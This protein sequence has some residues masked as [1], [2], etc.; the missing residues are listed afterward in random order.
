M[1]SD[2]ALDADQAGSTAGELL[3]A[4]LATSTSLGRVPAAR[5]DIPLRIP[6]HQETA[7]R[8]VLRFVARTHQ[9]TAWW[10]ARVSAT[11]RRRRSSPRCSSWAACR[12]RRRTEG[13]V[14]DSDVEGPTRCPCSS[15]VEHDGLLRRSGGSGVPQVRAVDDR[16]FQ[17]LGAVDGEDLDGLGV[18][19]EPPAAVLGVGGLGVG[20]LDPAGQPGPQVR[21]AQLAGGSLGVKQLADVPEVGELPLAGCVG[22]DPRRASLRSQH[23]P[24][25]R[26]HAEPSQRCPP[27]D[28]SGRAVPPRRPRRLRRPPRRSYPRMGSGP[29]PQRGIARRAARGPPAAGANARRR[30][31]AKTLSVLPT[32]AGTPRLGARTA[33]S[34]LAVGADEHGD[35]ARRPA[36]GCGPAGRPGS[37]RRAPAIEQAHDVGS[38]VTG[39]PVEG[40]ILLRALGR[41]PDE[42]VGGVQHPDPERGCCRRAIKPG[43]PMGGSGGHRAV[44]DVGMTDDATGSSRAS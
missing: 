28:A 10:R 11:Y 33:R 2:A 43:L 23:G 8:R 21:G 14:A 3:R 40:G 35:V 38:Q 1:Y 27:S 41:R 24:G 5:R 36:R 9:I 17:P 42:A 30:P 4:A 29:R 20:L 37:T 12:W 26:G 31:D 15:V 32:T 13:A 22:Q 39:D 25:Q 34:G 19:V 18:G 6:E 16:E 44:R 7:E